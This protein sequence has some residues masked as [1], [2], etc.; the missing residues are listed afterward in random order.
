[1]RE[2]EDEENNLLMNDG[3][4][5]SVSTS[6]RLKAWIRWG[7]LVTLLFVSAFIALCLFIDYFGQIDHAR[8]A[9]AIV[10]LGARVD[11]NRQPGDSLRARTEKAVA[12]Y[13]KGYAR[14]IICTG[15][16][17]DYPPAE[18]VAAAMLA[19][20]LGVP[21]EDLLLETQSTNTQENT[22]FAARICRK[23]RW[24]R[25][26]TVSDPY[27]LWRVQHNFRR[28]GLMTFPSPARDCQRNRNWTM[29]VRWTMR[30]GFAILRDYL[31][32]LV[33]HG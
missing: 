19:E 12:L 20:Q 13:K 30:E 11:A 27:H 1:M 6:S 33:R 3:V 26:I 16:L 15:G 4:T 18:A 22:R 28:V 24:T 2:R 8:H 25:V 10:I 14:K 29:R 7:V 32:I 9:Q 23:Q 17:G 5:G 21:P 31:Q